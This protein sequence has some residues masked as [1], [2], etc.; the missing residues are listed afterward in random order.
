MDSGANGMAIASMV[1]GII[2]ILLSCCSGVKWLTVIVAVVGIVFGIM[3]LQKK[4]E[5]SRG[6]AIAGIVCSIVALVMGVIMFICGMGVLMV[7]LKAIFSGA[8]GF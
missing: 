7:L 5:G 4:D 2:A 6:M 3:A 1:L 8:G